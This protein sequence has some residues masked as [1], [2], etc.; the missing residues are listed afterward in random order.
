MPTDLE[1]PTDLKSCLTLNKTYQAWVEQAIEELAERL[2]Q[3]R[4]LQRELPA[5]LAP[6]PLKPRVRRNWSHSL[7]FHHPYFRDINGMP[8]PKN[9]DTRAK[10]A[11]KEPDPYLTPSP[12]WTSD[13]NR[14][15]V[16]AVKTNLL[17]QS[18]QCLMDRKEALAKRLLDTEDPEQ[19]AQ[20]TER[21]DQLDKQ[22][23][24][25]RSLSLE[26]LLEQSSRPIDW[27]RIAN[28][29]M[30][31]HRTAFACEMRWRNLLDVRLNQ[32]PW[33]EAE[34][35]HLQA[36]ATKWAEHNWDKVAEEL[37]TGRS[38]F[39]CA[40]HYSTRLVTRH[41]KGPFSDEE[42]HRLNQ[43]VKVTTEEGDREVPWK[44]VSIFMVRRS[45]EQLKKHYNRSL[46]PSIHHGRW[47]PQEDYMLLIARKL[48]RDCSWAKVASMVPG[49][50]GGQCSERYKNVFA[51]RF[52][53]GRYTGDED[54]S[55][56]KLVQKHGPGHWS[57]VVEDMPWRTPNSVQ[58]RYRWLAKTLGTKQPTVT[59]LRAPAAPVNPARH[60][61]IDKRLDLYR[62]VCRQLTT[63]SLKHAALLLAKG[64]DE[65]LDR[66]TCLKL[67][68][69]MQQ[70]HQTGRTPSNPQVQGRALN[71]AIAQYAQPLHRP[72]L[73][74]MAAYEKQELHAVTNVLHDLHGLPRPPVDPDI[75]QAGTVPTFEEFFRKE[76]LGVPDEFQ[77]NDANLVLPLLPP[78]ETTVATYGRLVDRFANGNLADSLPALQAESSGTAFPEL[79]AALDANSVDDIRC[80]ECTSTSLLEDDLSSVGNRASQ[81]PCSRCE[82]LRAFRSNY[83]VLQARFIS[84]FFW[85]ALMDTLNVPETVELPA[86]TQKTRKKYYRTKSKLK[87]PWVKEKWKERKRLAAAAAVSGAVPE[88]TGATAGE[89]GTGGT[90][91]ED[92]TVLASH[93]PRPAVDA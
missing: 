16:D 44:Q 54:Y 43:L 73:P 67:Y 60:A 65:S 9:E 87:K 45:M 20:L 17:Q 58:M 76:V 50:T 69:K 82:Q 19:R 80:T 92:G 1:L 53:S 55:L 78:N 3:N 8:A 91:G 49:R 68:W 34:D 71:K 14:R 81:Q 75:E 64:E 4:L 6:R 32:N 39:Q 85:P 56:L 11:N 33:T 22:V 26:Q 40:T 5:Q 29:D 66:E 37:G 52:V 21:K 36:L 83:D 74:I 15:L 27:L 86:N 2:K 51:K 88:P 24:E 7:V 89:D 57:K 48:F 90:A 35:K 72:M 41:N 61:R 13:E 93:A 77:P 79:S 63:Q 18:L 10:L 59:D 30:P 28:K 84:Y 46:H 38:A 25:T 70:Q 42:N 47:T 23:D 62:H 31:S 12:P